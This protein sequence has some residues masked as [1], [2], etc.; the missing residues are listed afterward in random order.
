MLTRS[1]R[2]Q[3]ALDPLRLALRYGQTVLSW[4]DGD[5]VL[6]LSLGAVLLRLLRRSP[7]SR[8][9]SL[10]TWC[11]L[12]TAPEPYLLFGE[13]LS[14]FSLA[15]IACRA[16]SG[17]R[18]THRKQM[19]R[20]LCSRCATKGLGTTLAPLPQ[21]RRARS[22]GCAPGTRTPDPLI[23]SGYS[24]CFRGSIRTGPDLF[25]QVKCLMAGHPY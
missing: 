8:A 17:A 16:R 22:G 18:K 20:M 15:G 10:P 24:C 9:S 3:R 13:T 6:V 14:G 25:P 11:S 1:G 5:M 4:F 19:L 2:G 12:A 23:K 21:G 7:A